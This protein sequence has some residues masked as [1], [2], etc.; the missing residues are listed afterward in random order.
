MAIWRR[1][2]AIMMAAVMT[3]G[4]AFA[5]A[6]FCPERLPVATEGETAAA[7]DGGH[8]AAPTKSMAAMHEGC[9]DRAGSLPA[10]TTSYHEDCAGCPDCAGAMAVK[11]QAL[12]AAAA[13][14]VE[15]PIIVILTGPLAMVSQTPS[16]ARWRL[17]PPAVGPP[18]AS[19]P[20]SLK[21]ILRI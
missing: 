2:A 10:P 12:A 13:I 16:L 3:A 4:P 5:C 14:S 18:L 6:D 11:K 8:N 15:A 19:T 21:N 20:V 7:P 17:T 1:I 9:E